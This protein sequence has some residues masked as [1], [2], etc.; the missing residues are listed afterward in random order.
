MI[1]PCVKCGGHRK[2]VGFV[3]HEQDANL[4]VDLYRCESCDEASAET[5]ARESDLFH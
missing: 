3:P 4:R 2:R 1:A 5:V